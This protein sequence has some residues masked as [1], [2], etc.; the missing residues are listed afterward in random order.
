[1]KCPSL[2]ALLSFVR[3]ST[4]TQPP[5]TAPVASLSYEKFQGAYD[6]T[7]NI[8]YFRKIPFAAPPI[9]INRFR[10]PQPVEPVQNSTYNSSETFD[11]CPQRTVNGSEDCLYLGLYSRP[12]DASFSL[13]PVLVVFYGGAFIEG[14]G[15]F[16]IPPA[17]YPTLNA[18]AAND[19]VLVYPSYR[20]NAFGFLPGEAV[21]SDPDSDLNVGLLDQQAVLRWVNQHIT[22]FGGNPNS[23]TIWGQ[24]AGAGSVVAQV[25]G[26]PTMQK[27]LFTKA[28]TSSPFWSRTYQYD[29]KPAEV[30]YEQFASL[31]NCSGPQRLA[32][33]KR[34]DVQTLRTA[35]LAVSGSHTYNT[36]SYTWAP[37]I[38]PNFPFIL[39]RSRELLRLVESMQRLRGECTTHTKGK[40]LSRPDCSTPQPFLS[41]PA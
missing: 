31:T 19:Y 18:T 34:A 15:G 11:M 37:V 22:A 35:A 27:G 10:A 13:R 6:A 25:I 8:T 40:T 5:V 33:L 30:I 28:L 17:G 3:L 38:E 39:F 41:I 23:V 14:G 1:M 12:W 7:Y 26:N 16:N 24:S 21:A 32:C 29:S 20:V 4:Q 36:S 9:G 2:L